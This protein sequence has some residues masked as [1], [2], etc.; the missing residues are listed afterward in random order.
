MK[1]YRESGRLT[2][3]LHH[4][5]QG[6]WVGGIERWQPGSSRG[7]QGQWG[8]LDLIVGF[9]A[10]G[11]QDDGGILNFLFKAPPGCCVENGMWGTQD[12]IGEP[13]LEASVESG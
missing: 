6:E 7:R 1:F 9:L 8:P 4:E 10:C 11:R 13:S 5:N 3:K 2:S 12:R